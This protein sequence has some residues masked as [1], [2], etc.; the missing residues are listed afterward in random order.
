[1]NVERAEAAKGGA[2]ARRDVL[3]QQRAGVLRGR[4]GVRSG[5]LPVCGRQ[6][7]LR[8]VRIRED[9]R[10]RVVVADA[11]ALAVRCRRGVVWLC[12]GRVRVRPSVP[13]SVAGVRRVDDLPTHDWVRREYVPP[14]R[15]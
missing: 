13:W 2:R 15:A 5:R 10:G 7:G 1:M 14:Y 3:A 4:M 12:P 11:Q 9:G 6:C 8:R